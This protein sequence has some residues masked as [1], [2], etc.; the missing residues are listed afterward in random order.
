MSRMRYNLERG[1]LGAILQIST[2]S[3]VQHIIGE[4]ANFS[5]WIK[6]EGRGGKVCSAVSCKIQT[7]IFH[8]VL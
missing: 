8:D 2:L 4:A 1:N 5:D 3:D 7:C 6:M